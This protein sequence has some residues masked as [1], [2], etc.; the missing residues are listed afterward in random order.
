MDEEG[1]TPL[2]HAAGHGHLSIVKFILPFL[3]D[4]SP[5]SGLG[6]HKLTPLHLAASSGHLDIVEYLEEINEEVINPGTGIKGDGFTPLHYA[7]TYGH[8]NVVSFYTKLL[9]IL[10]KDPN[11]GMGNGATPLHCATDTMYE[12]QDSTEA[13]SG[14]VPVIRHLCN[15]LTDKNPK[16]AQGNTP[17]HYASAYGN[18][19]AVKYLLQHVEDKHPKNGILM[20]PLDVARQRN[21]SEV[22]NFFHSLDEIERLKQRRVAKT[23]NKENKHVKTF[24]TTGNNQEYDIES[25]LQSLG[26][27]DEKDKPKKKPK[28]KTKKTQPEK[29]SSCGA[30]A[31]EIPPVKIEEKTSDECS[32]CYEVRDQ[33]FVFYPCGHA[34]FCKGCAIRVF[35]TKDRRC[36]DCRTVIRDTFRVYQ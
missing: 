16:D 23:M 10:S 4:K 11:P 7:A 24:T 35:E 33:T 27:N 9:Q 12:A 3:S 25:V 13:H 21:Q 15:L 18:V 22:V 30:E 6:S 36:P 8:L 2:H 1:R 20:T 34:T 31:V 14:H 32:I 26:I 28:K 29:P 5:K 17:L 19:E